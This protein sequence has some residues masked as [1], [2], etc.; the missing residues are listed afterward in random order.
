LLKIY[1]APP[2][3]RAG[4]S[5]KQN[6]EIDACRVRGNFAILE[7]HLWKEQPLQITEI[8]IALF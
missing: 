4:Y 3:E 7:M 6:E 5:L 2:F 8:I 1:P